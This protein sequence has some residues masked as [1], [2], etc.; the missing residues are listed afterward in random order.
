MKG[1]FFTFLLT[2]THVIIKKC[3]KIHILC[4]NVYLIHPLG[5]WPPTCITRLYKKFQN[6]FKLIVSSWYMFLATWLLIVDHTKSVQK[7]CLIN[8]NT[9]IDFHKNI[10]CRKCQFVRG[11]RGYQ[12]QANIKKI[13]FANNWEFLITTKVYESW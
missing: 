6:N 7:W 4:S 9:S 10:F 13:T 5:C 12:I 3:W 11:G 8:L 1:N 2:T